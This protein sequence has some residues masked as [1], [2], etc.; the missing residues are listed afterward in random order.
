MGVEGITT[1]VEPGTEAGGLLHMRVNANVPVGAGVDVGGRARH[2][3][4]HR[5]ARKMDLDFDVHRRGDGSMEEGASAQ[6]RRVQARC[7]KQDGK[8]RSQGGASPKDSASRD[9]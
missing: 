4:Q 1:G 6:M 8:M 2:E 5:F 9:M 7:P 3:Q